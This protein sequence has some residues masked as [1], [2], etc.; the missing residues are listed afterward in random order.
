MRIV[1]DLDETQLAVVV[2][3]VTEAVLARLEAE[4]SPRLLPVREAAPLLGLTEHALRGQIARG[5]V[6]VH[7]IGGRILLD[8]AEIREA[9][10][11]G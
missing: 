10:R 4:R 1:V 5:R 11:H 6:P 9:A 2:G 8:V 3:R 7:R